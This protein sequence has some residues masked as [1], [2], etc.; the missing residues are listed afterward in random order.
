M[1]CIYLSLLFTIIFSSVV[2]QEIPEHISSTAV[3]EFL[4]ELATEGFFE[5]NSAVKPYSDKFIYSCLQKAKKNIS[6]LNKRQKKELYFYLTEFSYFDKYMINPKD[7]GKISGILDT[8]YLEL[9]P[10]GFRYKDSLTFL[11]IRP[12]WGI[13]YFRN[14]KGTNF[15]RWGGISFKMNI[16]LNLSSWASLR[17]NNVSEILSNQK[18][19]TTDEGGNYKGRKSGG[20]DYSEMRGGIAY[21]WEWG[22]LF[23]LKDHLQWGNN[24]HGA[25]IFSSKSPSFAQLK[26]HLNPTKWFEFNY[27]H[28][29][30]V[31]NVIDSIRSYTTVDGN[32]RDVMHPK[33]VAANMFTV[34]PFKGLDF[35]FGNSIIYSDINPHPA[36]LIPFMF[37]KSVDHWLNST[38][39]AGRGVGQNSQMYA[40]I[41]YRGLKNFH[42]YGT[43]FID[44][45]K[46][47]RFKEK[48]KYNPF[49]YKIG[50][51]N[52]NSLIENLSFGVEYTMTRPIVYEHYISTTTF[53][54][55]GYN[56][57]HYLR[58]NSDELYF[59]LDYHPL[60][61]LHLKC[62]YVYARH[63]KSYQYI[64]GNIAVTYPFMDEVRWTE[65]SINIGLS[66]QFAY[67]CALNINYRYNNS[68]GPDLEI[69]TPEFYQGKNNTLIFGFNF[70]F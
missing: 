37:Y 66:Y 68:S 48:G 38:D 1:K 70:G 4:D 27:I 23:V 53:E 69:F 26:L 42:F 62:E 58:S 19:F 51:K 5:I 34:K 35:S 24:Y 12:V 7:F 54:S 49:G 11:N 56:L 28:G 9:L 43:L 47:A 45:L 64:N 52:Y 13:E 2:G 63:G 36:Y 39:H 29:W 25:N 55:S 40:D 50:F 10:P 15:H 46:I 22:S 32:R 17:D 59:S 21:S 44:E 3:Y 8:W 41:S 60:A 6:L 67:N 65:E 31:S 33:Y 18:F 30:L 57:G 16:G 14:L 20:G 61:L